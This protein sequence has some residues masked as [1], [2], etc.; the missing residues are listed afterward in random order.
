MNEILK[1][2]RKCNSYKPLLDIPGQA[3]ACNKE[4]ISKY[5]QVKE[6]RKVYNKEDLT[7]Q[8][9]RLLNIMEWLYLC[10]I[11]YGYSVVAILVLYFMF[12]II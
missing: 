11:I 1:I 3:V 9:L 6:Q 2:F 8:P 7:P 10:Y 4:N 12:I 5:I